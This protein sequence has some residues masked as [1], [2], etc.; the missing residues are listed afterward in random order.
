MA[1]AEGRADTRKSGST[2]RSSRAIA[3]TASLDREATTLIQSFDHTSFT[4]A[5]IERAVAFWRDVMGFAVADLSLREGD[6]LGAVVGVPGARCRIAHLHGH[7]AHLEFIQYLTPAG[8]DVTGPP[9]RPG[10]A[11]VAFLVEDIE[12]L[13]TRMLEAGASEQG[14][15]TRCTSGP[16]DGLSRGLPQGSERHHCRAGGAA[17]A[18]GSGPPARHREGRQ[19]KPGRVRC[20]GSGTCWS[21]RSRAWPRFLRSAASGA[22]FAAGELRIANSGEPDTLDPHHV[23]GTWENRII[24][25]M[26]MG[27]TTEA[28]DGS[29]IPGAAESWTGQRRR[30]CL[31]LHAARPHLV[32]RHAGDRRRLRVRPAAHPRSGAGGRVRLAPLHDQE[33][34]GAERGRDRRAW[35]SWA[36]ARSTPRRSRS[37]SRARPPY[38]LEQLT[39]YT[40]F[41]VPK[42]KVEELGDD[43]VK[44]GN[45]VGNGAVHR[46]RVAAQHPRQGGEERRASTTPPTSRSTRS[47]YYPAEERNAATKRFRA[48][49]IDIQYDFASEQIDLLKENLPDE[50]RIAPYLGIYYYVINTRKRAVRR[51]GACARRWPWRSTARRSPTRCCAPASCPAYSFVPPGT[52]NYGEPAYVELEGHALRRSGSAEAKELL[53]EAGFGPDNPLKLTAAL[54][55]LREPQE[56][57]DRGRR[58]CGSSS[59]SQAELFN[60]EVK[61]HY[62]DLQEGNFEVARAA[63]IADYNDAAELPLSA[64]QLDRRA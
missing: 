50:T 39:H 27:L 33:R 6:W 21:G 1:S 13:A 53:A 43:W 56:D 40:A 60:S 23:S 26:F 37:R 10:T 51:P 16:A 58:R 29:V 54:Q 28:A 7:G 61:V 5:D 64:G 12:A 20:V 44:P 25:D 49:E 32:G 34:R 62:N 59:A 31:H 8:D 15:I 36:C 17:C 24:G 11:H 41:P 52:G 38:F 45:I 35:T 63:W 4:V 47:I 2:A 19:Q 55:H 46:G 42:H 9:N 57:R 30:H 22:A 48:G 18:H 3:A 14:R